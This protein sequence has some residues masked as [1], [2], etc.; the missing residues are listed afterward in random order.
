M[1]KNTFRRVILK[2]VA[3][4][5]LVSIEPRYLKLIPDDL[6][7]QEM[8]NKAFEKVPWLIHYVPLQLRMHEMCYR[9]VEKC[10]YPFRFVPDHLKTQEMCKKAVEKADIIWVISL[11]TLKHKKSVK[12]SLKMNGKP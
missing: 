2:Y 8:C 1:F 6:K 10:L 12:E 5:W 4:N 11:I 9:N 7:T 3:L